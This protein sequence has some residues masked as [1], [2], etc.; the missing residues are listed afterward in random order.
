MRFSGRVGLGGDQDEY[1][2]NNF[3]GYYYAYYHS[4]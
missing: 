2:L 4:S 1:Y 3:R